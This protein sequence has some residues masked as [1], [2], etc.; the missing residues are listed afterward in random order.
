MSFAV[1]VAGRI[2]ESDAMRVTKAKRANDN[3]A[4]VIGECR[5][6]SR[7]PHR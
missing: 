2:A 7:R 1:K 6:E 3:T 4:I 5:S